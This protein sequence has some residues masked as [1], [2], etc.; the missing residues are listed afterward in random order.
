MSRDHRVGLRIVKS[1][2]EP[3]PSKGGKVTHDARGTAVWDWAVDTGV[4]NQKSTAEL[5]ETLA[6]PAELSIVAETTETCEWRGDPYNR[7]R[8]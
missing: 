3:L 1:S 5:L 2:A 6:D 8:K 4:L 7:S